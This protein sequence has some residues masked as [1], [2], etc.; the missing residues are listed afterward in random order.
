MAQYFSEKN[1]CN[2]FM[3][4]AL[5]C[6]VKILTVLCRNYRYL[7]YYGEPS[8]FTFIQSTESIFSCLESKGKVYLF[9]P[10]FYE[11]THLNTLRVKWYLTSSNSNIFLPTPLPFHSKIFTHNPDK[12]N[13]LRR[14]NFY[15]P[16]HI[17]MGKNT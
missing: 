9:K 10:L 16:S 7:G 5:L 8:L 17:H 3:T 13:N 11:D 6:H 1:T 14:L 4:S 2:K 12:R 15:S